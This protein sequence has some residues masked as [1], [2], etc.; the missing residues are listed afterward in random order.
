MQDKPQLSL[1]IGLNVEPASPSAEP[2]EQAGSGL[3][4]GVSNGYGTLQDEHGRHNEVPKPSPPRPWVRYWARFID[5]YLTGITFGAA[6]SFA[7]LDITSW[8]KY[9]LGCLAILLWFPLEAAFLTSCGT[10]PGKW[11][12]NIRLTNVHEPS[13]RFSQYCVRA[14]AVMLQGQ[15]LGIPVVSLFTHLAAYNTLNTR[16]VTTWDENYRFVVRHGRI[17]SGRILGITTT[18]VLM[19][20]LHLYWPRAISEQVTLT[21]AGDHEPAPLR[22]LSAC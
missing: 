12:F 22:F 18:F 21:W 14:G 9:V 5:L 4:A 17:G 6:A 20:A 10:T 15:A 1:A 7:G 16:G 3:S 13:P 11:L 2:M 8:N 19:I